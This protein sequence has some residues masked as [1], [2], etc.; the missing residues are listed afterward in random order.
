MSGRGGRR[1]S[2]AL[3]V[4]IAGTMPITI[5][6]CRLVVME[7]ILEVPMCTNCQVER[8]WLYEEHA[9]KSCIMRCYLKHSIQR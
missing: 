7:Q 8:G 3:M 6:C 2:M 9:L 4:P 5:G 1:Q